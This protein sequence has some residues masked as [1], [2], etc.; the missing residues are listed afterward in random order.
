[1]KAHND[2]HAETHADQLSGNWSPGFILFGTAVNS[3]RAISNEWSLAAI[4]RSDR[5][6]ARQYPP[7]VNYSDISARRGAARRYTRMKYFHFHDWTDDD[8]KS[9]AAAAAGATSAAAA[10]ADPWFRAR[11]G[12]RERDTGNVK[13]RDRAEGDGEPGE[14]ERLR[15]REGG[16][17]WGV[18]TC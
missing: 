9:A 1:M 14:R 6:R 17:E 3:Y 10:D 7:A 2:Y 13:W 12:G 11:G 5:V 16:A 15:E 8:A 4:G 18:A